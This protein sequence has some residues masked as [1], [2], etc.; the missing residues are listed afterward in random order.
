VLCK[1]IESDFDFLKKI[2][3]IAQYFVKHV[4]NL[5]DVVFQLL[6]IDV[7]QSFRGKISVRNFGICKSLH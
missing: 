4:L 7:I 5:N 6:E 2:A 3:Q 1:N